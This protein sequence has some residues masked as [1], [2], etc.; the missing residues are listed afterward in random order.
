MKDINTV[1]N[2]FLIQQGYDDVIAEYSENE[3]SYYTSGSFGNKVVLGGLTNKYA[4]KIFAEYCNELGLKVSIGIETLTFLHEV[5]HYVTLDLLEEEEE[6]ISR[7]VKAAIGFKENEK[8]Y[9]DDDY[10]AYMTCP[11]E[12]AATYNAIEFCN[13]YPD[14]AMQLDQDIQE[15]L[16]NK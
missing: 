3:D 11:E 8:D 13:T 4:D 10:W 14:A 16:Y 5:G 1:L 9:T 15:A 2:N 7:L 12:Y 6:D